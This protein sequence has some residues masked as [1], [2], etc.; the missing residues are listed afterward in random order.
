MLLMDVLKPHTPIF[1]R[2]GGGL[3]GDDLAGTVPFCG[4]ER[5][6]GGRVR[7]VIG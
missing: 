7:L 1:R 6:F 5:V 4:V 2:T 3:T